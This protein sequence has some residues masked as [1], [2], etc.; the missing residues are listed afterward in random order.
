MSFVLAKER[1]VVLRKLL[2]RAWCAMAGP[3]RGPCA[4]SSQSSPT[5]IPDTDLARVL[6]GGG[7]EEHR[8]KGYR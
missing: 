3:A 7:E 2:S 8:G 1:Q 5:W 6:P 4:E